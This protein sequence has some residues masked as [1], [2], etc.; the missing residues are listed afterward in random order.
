MS[1]LGYANWTTLVLR[2]GPI[3]AGRQMGGS[4]FTVSAADPPAGIAVPHLTG[5]SVHQYPAAPSAAPMN[6]DGADMVLSIDGIGLEADFDHLLEV[7]QRAAYDP[8]EVFI[9]IPTVDVWILRGDGTTV[10][11]LTRSFA[12]ATA[13]Y[14]N[15]I[16]TAK[17]I[18]HPNSGADASPIALSIVTA[19]TPTST[20]FKV[21]NTADGTSIELA[22]QDAE[23]GR[24]VVLKYHPLRK[25]VIGSTELDAEEFNSMILEVELIEVV[26][27]RSY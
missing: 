4:R 11:T 24:S 2:N 10:W 5:S 19:G 15:Y 8:V 14:A 17:I 3:I 12:F 22:N 25:F 21:D 9:E 7:K 1:T 23:V 6:L 13:G 16:P 27:S 20:E 18:D 26:P